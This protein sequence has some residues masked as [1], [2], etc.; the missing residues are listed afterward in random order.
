MMQP[1][2]DD[3][4][5]VAVLEI[6]LAHLDERNR[7]RHDDLIAR[8]ER[9]EAT[10]RKQAELLSQAMDNICDRVN[11]LEHWRIQRTAELEAD[12]AAWKRWNALISAAI[13]AAAEGIKAAFSRLQ[14][15]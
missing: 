3:H 2:P 10:Q 7:E 14:G 12:M 5:T 4:V 13:V 11:S 9:H 1:R 6:K 8:L 15:N